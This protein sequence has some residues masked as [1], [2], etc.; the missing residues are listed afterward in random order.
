MIGLPK[1]ASVIPVAR[2][3]LRAPAMLRPWVVV[4]ERY[5][6]ISRLA[7]FS[8]NQDSKF[9]EDYHRRSFKTPSLPY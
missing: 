5:W 6:G 1:S 4:R 7:K 9:A 3:K 2:H 8:M